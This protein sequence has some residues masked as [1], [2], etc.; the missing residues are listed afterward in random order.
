MSSSL[1][2]EP[3]E[4]CSI[5]KSL[6]RNTLNV[7]RCLTELRVQVALLELH[8]VKKSMPHSWQRALHCPD[9]I[10][11]LHPWNWSILALWHFSNPPLS[12]SVS[13]T[14]KTICSPGC[15]N[16]AHFPTTLVLFNPTCF[17]LVPSTVSDL[18]LCAPLM[19]SY[20][21]PAARHMLVEEKICHA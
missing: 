21:P 6:S 10:T 11:I 15:Q 8:Y 13:T 7:L 1:A 3:E 16:K 14:P 17:L 5:S 4:I 20:V 12:S 19:T 18:A 9:V 2:V